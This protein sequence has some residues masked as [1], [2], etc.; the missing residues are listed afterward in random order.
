MKNIKLIPDLIPIT[1]W[2]NNLRSTDPK[3]WNVIRHLSYAK[4]KEECEICGAK[5]PLHCHEIWDYNMETQIQKLT[6][7][8]ALCPACHEVK[9]IGL[10]R[11]RDRL[12]NAI[13][14][15]QKVNNI[16]KN[17]ANEI[18]EEAFSTWS[19][20]SKIPWKLDLSDLE[21]I[22]DGLKSN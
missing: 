2:F 19:I 12:K 18:I 11:I 5:V 1:S 7:L 17:E 4:A 13:A 9:H 6:G 21:S 10:A 16:E 8:I 14:H 3:A 15:M 22:R 20:R